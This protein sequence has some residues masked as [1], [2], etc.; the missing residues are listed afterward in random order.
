M[1]A[2]RTL[3]LGILLLGALLVFACAGSTPNPKPFTGAKCAEIPTPDGTKPPPNS[4]RPF[5]GAKVAAIPEAP[6]KAPEDCIP[7]GDR[8]WTGSKASGVPEAEDSEK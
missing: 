3:G 5:T 6:D 2:L 7:V 4:D 1:T 8:P